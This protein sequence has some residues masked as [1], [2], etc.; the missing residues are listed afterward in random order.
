M[1]EKLTPREREDLIDLKRSDGF[2]LFQR[3]IVSPVEAQISVALCGLTVANADEGPVLAAQLRTLRKIFD[4][5]ADAIA[6]E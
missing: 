1:I 4:D 3:L 6:A 2:K 5:F